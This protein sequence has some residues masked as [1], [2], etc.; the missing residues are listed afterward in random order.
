VAA[1]VSAV[2][3]D[4]HVEHH[5]G[6]GMFGSRTRRIDYP[7]LDQGIV[8]LGHCLSAKWQF[9]MTGGLHPKSSGTLHRRLDLFVDRSLGGD[10]KR[11]TDGASGGQTVE[12]RVFG[13][14]S[15]TGEMGEVPTRRGVGLADTA[16][17]QARTVPVGQPIEERV[18]LMV[19]DH[20]LPW[21]TPAMTLV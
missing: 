14:E 20:H 10:P 16:H 11:N 15:L 21:R 7:L 13:V 19:A 17:Y 12:G 8:G 1:P 4:E 18:D 2:F 3:V 9:H 5:P 6:V